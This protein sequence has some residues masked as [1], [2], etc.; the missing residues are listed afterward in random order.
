[1]SEKKDPI[2]EKTTEKGDTSWGWRKVVDE[3]RQ[4]LVDRGFPILAKPQ[5]NLDDLGF[6]EAVETVSPIALANMTMRH[7]AWFSYVTVE[8]AFARAELRA[9]EEI[10]D[11][12][13]GERMHEI[14][15]TA[16]GRVVKDV[17]RSLAIVGDDK[18]KMWF[19][20]RIELEQNDRLLEGLTRGLEIRVR[21]LEGEG[22]RRAVAQKIEGGR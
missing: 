4:R 14:G 22:I 10:L 16:D 9:L 12:M 7:Q 19:R 5:N 18:L 1:M 2:V 11:V 3:A 15:R 21:A 13:L 17:L 6:I 20:R 8:H